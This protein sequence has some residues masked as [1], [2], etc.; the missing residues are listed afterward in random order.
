[1]EILQMNTSKCARWTENR[2]NLSRISFKEEICKNL[3]MTRK[4]YILL[5]VRNHIFIS[6]RHFSA[7]IWTSNCIT[8]PPT[9]YS[10]DQHYHMSRL[11]TKPT[12]WHMGPAKTQTSLGI[13]PV[14]SESSL[15][16]WRIIGSLATHWAGSEDS[17]QT[18]RMSRLIWVFAGRTSFVGF[19]MR[20]LI[21]NHTVNLGMYKARR[22]A[23]RVKTLISRCLPNK[24][25]QLI[26]CVPTLDRTSSSSIS[27]VGMLSV[28]LISSVIYSMCDLL[29]SQ[30]TLLWSYSLKITIWK[31]EKTKIC[32]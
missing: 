21:Y 15:S 1:M 12:K 26:T 3:R 5:S 30:P 29:E 24:H 8:Q 17:D 25:P 32:V 31:E 4:G 13:H 7:K 14:W 20:R 23:H 2:F 11:T 16:A 6:H 19:V 28:H 27:L 10:D 9:Y 22:M 18:G